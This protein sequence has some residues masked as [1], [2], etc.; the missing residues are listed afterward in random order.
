MS[1]DFDNTTDPRE[2]PELAGLLPYDRWLLSVAAKDPFCSDDD[3]NRLCDMLNIP[4][5]ASVRDAIYTTLG[6]FE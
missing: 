6:G 2:L 4:Q 3:W 1:A 5:K